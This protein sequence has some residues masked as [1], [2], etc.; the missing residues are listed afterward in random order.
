VSLSK[1]RP[2][3]PR[4]ADGKTAANRSVCRDGYGAR[5]GDAGGTGSLVGA[6]SFGSAMRREGRGR[7]VCG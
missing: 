4:P 1:D 3:D 7:E 6:V 5:L 2:S